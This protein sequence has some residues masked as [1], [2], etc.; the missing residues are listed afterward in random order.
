M[1]LDVAFFLRHF[2]ST[3]DWNW[4]AGEL[5]KL[6]LSDFANMVFSAVQCWFGEESPWQ[7][8]YVPEDVLGDFLEFTLAGGVYGYAGRDKGTVFLKQQNRNNADVSRMGTLLYHA[9]PPVKAMEWRYTYLQKRPW[10]LPAAWVHRLAA[11]R[12]D[13]GRFADHTRDVLRADTEEV[14]KLKRL[15]KEIGL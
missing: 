9:F 2:G 3:L 5:E 6:A 12:K 14:R 4:V 15:Y 10:L 8:R 13:W 7:L 11:S 1:Y